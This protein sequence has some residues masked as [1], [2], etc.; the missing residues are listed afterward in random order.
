MEFFLKVIIIP[1]AIGF[2]GGMIFSPMIGAWAILVSMTIVIGYLTT[3]F[4]QSV[5]SV[6]NK[7]DDETDA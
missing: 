5:L 6:S 2:V 1:A 3:P 7:E 4:Y